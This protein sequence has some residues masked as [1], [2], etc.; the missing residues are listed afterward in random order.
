MGLE[1][2][3]SKVRSFFPDETYIA[4]EKVIS[5]NQ[6]LL[7][8]AGHLVYLNIHTVIFLPGVPI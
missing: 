7:T 4:V 3:R 8:G 5:V 1:L 6:S 2:K